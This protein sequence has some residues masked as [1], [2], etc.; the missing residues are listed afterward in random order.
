ME[1]LNVNHQLVVTRVS[2]PRR[3]ASYYHIIYHSAGLGGTKVELDGDAP[4]AA[5]SS[6]G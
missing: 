6:A 5:V 4:Q 3:D 2:I 1:R